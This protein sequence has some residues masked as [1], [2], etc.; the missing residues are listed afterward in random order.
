MGS[1]DTRRTS[2]GWLS[3][4]IGASRVAGSIGS[5][6]I[7]LSREY[8]PIHCDVREQLKQGFVLINAKLMTGNAEISLTIR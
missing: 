1:G 3:L 6:S 8:Q 4:A 2:I 7:F 5:P